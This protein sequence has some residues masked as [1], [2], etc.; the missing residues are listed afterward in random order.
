MSAPSPAPKPAPGPRTPGGPVPPKRSLPIG[1]GIAALTKTATGAVQQGAWALI[2]SEGLILTGALP[3]GP[4]ANVGSGLLVAI[5]TLLAHPDLDGRDVMLFVAADAHRDDIRALAPALGPITV[6]H[7]TGSLGHVAAITV[8][9]TFPHLAPPP[10][11]EPVELPIMPLPR[12]LVATDGSAGRGSGRKGGVGFA[13]VAENGAHGH[14]ATEDSKTPLAAE[15]RAVIAALRGTKTNR[16]V[17]IVCDSRIAIKVV[18][19][20]HDPERRKADPGY[21][22]PAGLN[23]RLLGELHAAVTDR[24]IT[25]SWVRGHMDVDKVN[26]ERV[27]AERQRLV[28]GLNCAADRIAVAARRAMQMGLGEDVLAETVTHVLADTFDAKPVPA[29]VKAGA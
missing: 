27:D 17:H 19:Y 10:A 20:A 24:D 12:L 7:S 26:P 14:G 9:E 18:K 8:A 3:D 21:E 1:V 4:G 6:H 2:T 25:I 29:L 23:K 16:P 15:V 13:W 22:W 5:E 28:V 11:P